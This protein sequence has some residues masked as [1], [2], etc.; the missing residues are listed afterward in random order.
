MFLMRYSHRSYLSMVLAGICK[1]EDGP[2][3]F[4]ALIAYPKHQ[5]GAAPGKLGWRSR[6][7]PL[8]VNHFQPP[9]P[10]SSSRSVSRKAGGAG[11]YSL[12]TPT[13][14]ADIGPRCCVFASTNG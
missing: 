5:K 6:Y 12:E 1:W 7:S 8:I 3:E 11:A 4:T 14:R 13:T 9:L 2:I 10:R